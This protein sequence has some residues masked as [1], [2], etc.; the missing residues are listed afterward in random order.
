MFRLILIAVV[1]FILMYLLQSFVFK[2]ASG[3]IAKFVPLILVV[4]IY[5]GAL[6]V[7]IAEFHFGNHDGY[8]FYEFMASLAA[9]I[10]TVGLAAVGAAWLVEY[11]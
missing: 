3:T 11:V 7:G 9:G 1:W 5:I 2:R 8:L 6:A 4:L 10:N